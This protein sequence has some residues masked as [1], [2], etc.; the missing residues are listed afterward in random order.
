MPMQMQMPMPMPME[1]MQTNASA[2]ANAMLLPF[3]FGVDTVPVGSLDLLRAPS[4]TFDASLLKE[5]VVQSVTNPYPEAK[6]CMYLA[7]GMH[8]LCFVL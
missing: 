6:V 2:N 5:N 3:N 1:Q 7:F 8:I 4:D